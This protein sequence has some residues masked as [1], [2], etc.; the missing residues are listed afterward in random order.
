MAELSNKNIIVAGGTSGIGLSITSLCASLGANVWA[1]G[2]SQEYIDKAKEEVSGNVTFVSLDIH[3]TSALQALF[4]EVGTIDHLACNATGANRT[5]APFMKQTA[6]QFQEAFGKFWGYTNVVREAIPFIAD[7]GSITLTSGTPARKARPGQISLSCVGSAVEAF[8][9]ALAPEVA[10][11]RVNVVAPGIIDT[12]MYS[13]M[14]DK[15]DEQLAN[16]TQ[17]FP[18]KRAGDPG[19]VASAIVFLMQNDYVTG[20]TIDVDGGLL[21]S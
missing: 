17:K 6:E 7:T 13:W 16:L 19:E 21:L 1:I 12:T 4:K 3:D 9:R 11:I 5:I 18:A 10:P 15:K 20:S 2:R 14:G 8:T